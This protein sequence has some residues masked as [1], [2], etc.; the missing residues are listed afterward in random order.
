[1]KVLLLGLELLVELGDDKTTEGGVTLLVGFGALELALEERLPISEAVRIAE[2]VLGKGLHLLEEKAV[3][4]GS[5]GPFAFVAMIDIRLARAIDRSALS[6]LAKA[7]A[8]RNSNT[9][10]RIVG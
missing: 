9:T 5:F 6:I 4:G 8:T 2:F 7:F 1:M 10:I 3:V